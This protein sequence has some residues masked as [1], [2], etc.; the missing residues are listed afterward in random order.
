[1]ASGV[2]LSALCIPLD[3]GTVSGA[4]PKRNGTTN[5]LHSFE[6]DTYVDPQQKEKSQTLANL[7]G[8]GGPIGGP[9]HAPLSRAA[10]LTEL[11][12]SRNISGL[13]L[14]ELGE[15]YHLMEEKFHP[16]EFCQS[17]KP[18]LDFIRSV[19][20]LSQYVEPLEKVILIRLI[21]QLSKVYQTIQISELIKLAFFVKSHE[22]EKLLLEAVRNGYVDLRV[23]HQKGVLKFGSQTLDADKMRGQL[24]DLSKNLFKVVSKIGDIGGSQKLAVEEAKKKRAKLYELIAKNLAR[25][26]NK[27]IVRKKIIERRKEIEEQILRLKEKDDEEKN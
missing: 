25:E 24:T 5:L 12:S 3:S 22:L 2:L 14:P 23:D 20:G 18:K 6:W 17:L 19:R 16:L 11:T 27:I 10:L 15:L 26:K 8:P 13:V 7:L 9:V 21:Q 1:M 4:N